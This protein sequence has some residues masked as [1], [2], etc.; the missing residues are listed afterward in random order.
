M[1]F[2]FFDEIGMRDAEQYDKIMELIDIAREEELDIEVIFSA[3]KFMKINP[4]LSPLEAVE[5]G[6]TEWMK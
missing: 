6:F 2:L 1:N 5:E 4:N 3:L